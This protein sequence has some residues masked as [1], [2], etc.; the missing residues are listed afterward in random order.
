M[1]F[2]LILC[3]EAVVG[4]DPHF[5]HPRERGAL[6]RTVGCFG[7]GRTH[8]CGGC[9]PHGSV[10]ADS[11]GHVF[12]VVGGRRDAGRVGVY[13]DAHEHLVG[14]AV[15]LLELNDARALVD[16]VDRHGGC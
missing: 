6:R 3:V 13:V 15:A 5:T 2:C 12:G 4:A 11:D 1:L 9:C 10:V 14:A 16:A 8:T 7:E